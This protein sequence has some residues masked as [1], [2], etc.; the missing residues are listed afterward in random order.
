MVIERELLD[1]YQDS[2][3]VEIPPGLM[4]RGGAYYSTAATSLISS[5]HHG[6][7]DFHILNVP[8]Q[9]AVAGWPDDWVLEIP[10]RVD[11]GQVRPIPTEPLALGEAGLLHLVKSYELLAVEAA[12]HG[13]RELAIQALAAHPLGPDVDKVVEVFDDLLHINAEYL[14]QFGKRDQK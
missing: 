9:G 13:D 5:L 6:G 8:H 14:P 10:C 7:Q 2:G 4:K 3:N 12:V 11:V 1:Y